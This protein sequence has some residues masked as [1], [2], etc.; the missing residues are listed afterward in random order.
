MKTKLK[1]PVEVVNVHYIPEFNLME[2]NVIYVSKEYSLAMHKCLCGCG[3]IAATPI[4]EDVN[5]TSGWD[6]T[7]D[8]NNK[9][10][11]KPSILN[12]NCPNRYH[13]VI[14]NGIANIL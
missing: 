3:E 7:I 10:T 4:N 5:D 11:F 1:I 13:Y 9:I 12:T 2:E 6:V 8:S 14:T